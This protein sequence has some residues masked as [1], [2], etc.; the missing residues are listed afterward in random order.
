MRYTIAE[1]N[2]GFFLGAF[3]NHGVFAK[4]DIFGLSKAFSFD[5]KQDA[6]DFI[7]E[8]MHP[9]KKNFFV[10]EIETNEKYIDVTEL[11]K[12]GYAKYTHCMIDSIPMISTE[13]H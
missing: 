13:I 9:S 1:E 7:N 4:N 3:K 6:E 2:L 11:L 12:N 10:I 8:Y 5:T